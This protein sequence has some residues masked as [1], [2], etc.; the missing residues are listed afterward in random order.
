MGASVQRLLQAGLAQ[1]TQRVY[2]SGKREYLA[3]C[4][5]FD[6]PPLPATEQKLVKFTAFLAN[7]G[8]KHQTMKSYL[9]ATRHL[10]IEC[11]GGDPRVESMPLLELA[12]RGAKREQAGAAKRTRL[13]ITPRVLS[14]LRDVWS[15]EASDPDIVM[16]WAVCCVG[17]F[18]S[19]E[20]VVS[21]SGAFDPNQHLSFRDVTVDDPKHPNRIFLRIKQSKT[22][23]FRKGITICLSKTGQQLC[24]VAALLSYLVMR[25]KEDGPLFHLRGGG[26]L[27]RAQLV[28]RLRRALSWA[29]LDPEKYG[30]HSFRVGAATTAAMCGVPVDVIKTLERWRSQAYQLH[31]RIP[32]PQLSEISKCLAGAEV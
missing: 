22:D 30:G 10:Q 12:L 8:L 29:G 16:M 3:F 14:R 24:P 11:G 19:G 25:G 7:Q 23:P 2:A 13:P 5:A 17:F 1:S 21:D 20:L 6:T 27:M 18:R 26:P 9:S 15:L 28:S 4:R 32:D 31:I